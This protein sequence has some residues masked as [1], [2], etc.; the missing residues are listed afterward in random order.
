MKFVVDRIENNTAVLENIDT[1]EII[2]INI[3]LLPN[4]IKENNI[5]I[6]DNNEYVIDKET[7]KERKKDLL[8]RFNKLK[9]K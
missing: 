8:S 9:K 4:N 6:Y 1:K 5:I 3:N 2:E 7:E